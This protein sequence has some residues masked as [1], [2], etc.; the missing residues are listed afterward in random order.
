RDCVW[1]GG[2]GMV[3]AGRAGG[4]GTERPRRSRPSPGDR[5]VDGSPELCRFRNPA[6]H[7]RSIAARLHPTRQASFVPTTVGP[8][9]RRMRG[10]TLC[11]YSAATPPPPP[12]RSLFHAVACPSPLPNSFPP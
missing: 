2:V 1:D 11:A 7:G 9:D 12:H 10:Y 3:S 8:R 6:H 4:A 5:L